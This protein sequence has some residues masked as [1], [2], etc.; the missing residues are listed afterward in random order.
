MQKPNYGALYFDDRGKQIELYKLLE[1]PVWSRKTMPNAV[2]TQIQ[3]FNESGGI[4]VDGNIDSAGQFS[5][6]QFYIAH[7]I[8]TKLMAADGTPI[9]SATDVG[10]V[11]QV[12][13]VSVWTILKNI[14]QT[15]NKPLA[16][17]MVAPTSPTTTGWDNIWR[18]LCGMVKLN[19]PIVFRPGEKFTFT[20]TTAAPSDLSAI[21]VLH[22][23][24]GYLGV[25]EAVEN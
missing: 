22:E 17:Y 23:F 13:S 7:E 12:L 21:D 1:W 19:Q 8:H 10:D 11:S 5:N 15:I 3:Y 14:G 24:R 4:T 6:T 18:S 16:S 2:T 20:Q 9:G 25:E